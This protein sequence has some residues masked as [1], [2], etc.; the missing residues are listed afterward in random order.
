MQRKRV[1]S[2]AA[3]GDTLPQEQ[4]IREL[5][6][7]ALKGSSSGAPDAQSLLKF[8]AS[9]KVLE[10]TAAAVCEG[11]SSGFLAKKVCLPSPSS[12][13]PTHPCC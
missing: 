2:K 6:N 10:S 5:V 12:I 1:L 3:L 11:E 13:N 8:L 9:P 4:G 7:L